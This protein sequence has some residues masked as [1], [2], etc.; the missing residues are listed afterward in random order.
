[1]SFSIYKY[2]FKDSSDLWA[3]VVTGKYKHKKFSA[4]WIK[5]DVVD[6]Q[7]AQ[8][9]AKLARSRTAIESLSNTNT[10]KYNQNQNG[11]KAFSG[12]S[13]PLRSESN[14][15]FRASNSNN[16]SSNRI[17][18][19]NYSANRKVI[20]QRQMPKRNSLNINN[21]KGPLLSSLSTNSVGPIGSGN[22]GANSSGGRGR[23]KTLSTS[24]SGSNN[25]VRTKNR[26][27]SRP[28]FF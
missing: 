2:F 3:G 19:S 28:F 24:S 27:D 8:Q 18:N 10:V 22:G 25:S 17:R 15:V 9:Q 4:D 12:V 13:V 21:D 20:D 5:N 7:L 11:Q 23:Q 26:P 14:V 6:E 1:L 16:N